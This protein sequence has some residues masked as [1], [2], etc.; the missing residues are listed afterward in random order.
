MSKSAH[1]ERCY[2]DS[3]R[4][5]VIVWLLDRVPERV[6]SEVLDSYWSPSDVERVR[7]N[8]ERLWERFGQSKLDT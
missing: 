2:P 4:A 6:R 8:A 5:R 1:G 7:Q 3:W